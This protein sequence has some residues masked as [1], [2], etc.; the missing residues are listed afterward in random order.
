MAKIIDST[1]TV[2]LIL[3]GDSLGSIIKGEESTL[4]VTLDEIIYHTK[5]VCKGV[6]NSLVVSDMPF[7]S[8]QV[9][10][11]KALI[12]AGKILKNTNAS[13]VKIEGGVKIK[14]TIKALVDIDIPVLGHVG[15]TP[16]SYHRMGGHKIQGSE[17]QIIED[18]KAVEEAGAFAI[19]LEGIPQRTASK[20]SNLLSIPT[21]GIA[22]GEGSCDGKILVINDLLGFNA[23]ELPPFVKP[24]ANLKSDIEIAVKKYGLG[25]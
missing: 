8:Y 16:Q 14:N 6:V 5:A 13:A 9:S 19:V 17:N 24:L 20:I 21:I 12:S 18:A 22:C 15:L 1:N 11:E 23:D 7:M 10:I 3:V 4:S 2:D 25:K